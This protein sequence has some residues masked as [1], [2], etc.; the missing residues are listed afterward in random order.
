[1][2]SQND[3]TELTN[4]PCVAALRNMA[5]LVDRMVRDER[6][7]GGE[8]KKLLRMDAKKPV[9]DRVITAME[10]FEAYVHEPQLEPILRPEGRWK[11]AHAKSVANS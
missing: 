9:M 1:M 10:R 6:K 11:P 3:E 4:E 7:M 8:I 5:G 2:D